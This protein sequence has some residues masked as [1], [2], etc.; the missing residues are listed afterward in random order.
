MCGKQE[1]SETLL[2][3][4]CSLLPAVDV[5]KTLHLS[6][7]ILPT[8]TKNRLDLTSC[9]AASTMLL[10]DHFQPLCTNPTSKDTFNE[11]RQRKC[12]IYN[13]CCFIHPKRIS[14]VPSFRA[15]MIQHQAFGSSECYHPL[16]F[17]EP[18]R[19]YGRKGIQ[20]PKR[21]AETI[22]TLRTRFGWREGVDKGWS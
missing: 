10:Y 6:Q 11:H 3:I 5:I 4:W 17:S 2:T 20:D 18:S 15:A 16:G 22:Y 14:Y 21:R 9:A 8:A 7:M 13:V 19:R 1:A 12:N